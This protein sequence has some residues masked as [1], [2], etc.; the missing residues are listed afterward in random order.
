M[1]DP[2]N[3]KT[4]L[5]DKDS[6]LT[7]RERQ[8]L[9]NV[10]EEKAFR[11]GDYAT[12]KKL[13][14]DDVGTERS[15]AAGVLG[16][17]AY[18]NVGGF[19][20]VKAIREVVKTREESPA[21]KRR[22]IVTKE[23][24]T[25]IKSLEDALSKQEERIQQLE[26][27][28]S[29]KRIQREE[30]FRQRK[31]K[32]QVTTEVLDKEFNDIIGE[33]IQSYKPNVLIDPKQ[34]Q[35]LVKA[36]KNKAQKG[37]TNAEQVV[38]EIYMA[39][40][41]K[42]EGITKRDIRD[43][44]S[45]YG[46]STERTRDELQVSVADL[47]RQMEIASKI[48]DLEAGKTPF[49]KTIN[50]N[51]P[52]ETLQSLKDELKAKLKESDIV[53]QENLAKTKEQI[54]TR[55]DDINDRILRGDYVKK[56]K[57]VSPTDLEKEKLQKELKETRAKFNDIQKNLGDK[58]SDQEVKMISDLSKKTN[59]AKVKMDNSKP[60]EL[61]K[62]QTKEELEYGN[63]YTDYSEYIDGLKENANKMTWKEFKQ[64]PLG[65]LIK[66]AGH[67][68]GMTK[69]LKATFDNSGLFNQNLRVLLTH[70]TVWA[71]NGLKSFQDIWNTIGGENVMKMVNSDK[72][73]R[74]NYRNGLYKK[75]KLAIGTVEEAFPD[76]KLLE[77]IPIAGRVHK[78]ANTA[79]T[80]MA[81]RNRMDVFDLLV[82]H[83]ENIG[84]DY[85]GIGK[86]VN[87]LTGRG[88]LGKF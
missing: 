33:F 55:I 71:K 50:K 21:G 61:G 23:Y 54:Q 88:S 28:K 37:I 42:I 51:E 69:S 81:Y 84:A 79:F 19:S 48:E 68:P 32:R 6:N 82:K 58:I 65:N 66:G 39:L 45:G 59:D 72:V 10:L 63:A 47:K 85:T 52:T 67:I 75:E 24:E 20:P 9:A 27:Q 41:D 29:Y 7:P 2:E 8:V 36:V 26:T 40:A 87:S 11:E 18:E 44:I 53:E 3:A 74:P 49:K 86:I 78:A 76:S 35:I 64:S 31:E 17:S 62:P 80:A 15:E 16:A 30:S 12:I 57:T 34:V 60:R 5:F 43:A 56:E 70:P 77:K 83:A 46:K 1:K 13:S 22:E 38:D 73:S 4:Q 14:L 25:K